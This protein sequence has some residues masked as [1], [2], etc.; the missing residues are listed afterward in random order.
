MDAQRIYDVAI[1]GGGPAGST[2]ATLCAKAG[3]K[4]VVL[5]KSRFPRH[6]VCGDCVNPGCM[7][8]LE[9][10]GVREAVL[11]APHVEVSRVTFV[12]AR[13]QR[14]GIRLE[15]PGEIAISRRVF[16]DILLRRSA[17][18][19]VEV[20]QEAPVRGL[21]RDEAGNWRIKAGDREYIARRLVAADGRNSTVAR[22]LGAAPE[23]RRDRVGLQAH[24]ARATGLEGG[25]ELHLTR[26]GYCGVAPLG[27]GVTNFCLVA[28]GA[29]LDAL[30]ALV[31]ERFGIPQEQEWRAI[32]PLERAPVG[33]LRDGVVYV[34]DSAR[35]VEPFTGE[36]IYYALQSGRLA[37][38]H[39][40]AGTLERYPAEHAGLY[41]RRI[42]INQ[43]ARWAV[44]SPG[45]GA[46]LLRVMSVHPASLGYLVSQVTGRRT[47]AAASVFRALGAKK[48]QP[49]TV[50]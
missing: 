28:T 16:D 35:V 9:E 25:I 44:T 17:E 27:D 20:V 13:G 21:S 26:D 29:R 4:T 30:K 10:L 1:A 39:I 3:L 6:K 11:A 8:L 19:G 12:G 38:A 22:L 14:V 43:I 46:M 41:R 40:A 34:G 18:A 48:V 5:E 32:A 37:A 49:P 31:C 15:G 2:C 42:W 36:G 7:P 23:A 50:E 33:P 47:A 45:R 24:V